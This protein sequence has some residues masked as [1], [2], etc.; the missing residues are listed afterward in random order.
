MHFLAKGRKNGF[1]PRLLYGML[2]QIQSA[3]VDNTLEVEV[4]VTNEQQR[5]HMD[6]RT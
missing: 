1:I 5:G 6:A 3:I 4:V 2:S